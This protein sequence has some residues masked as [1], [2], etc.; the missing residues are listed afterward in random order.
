MRKELENL[1]SV[2]ASHH[3]DCYIVPSGDYHG[4]EYLND[5]FKTRKY[6]SGFTGSAGTLLVT[7]DE[8]KLWTDGRYFIQAAEELMDSGIDLMKMQEPDVPTI[9]EYFEGLLSDS[10][11]N[12]PESGK[13]Y[14]LGFDGMILDNSRGQKLQEI[15]E[16]YN[17]K[18]DFDNDLVGE[19]WT[20]RPALTGNKIWKLPLSSAGIDYETKIKQVRELM[21]N[22][23]VTHHFISGLAENAWLYNLRGSDVAYTPVFFSFSM[24]T[25]DSVELF[26]L[27]ETYDN[28]I[29][30]E[31]VTIR[32]YFD[33]KT[34]I[35]TL[36]AGA[37]LL[38]DPK[39]VSYA[40]F[41]CV[42]DG[43]EIIEDLSP[44]TRLKA[45]K[46]PVE[47][48]S[49]INAHIKDGVA[50]VNFI[51]WL[52]KKMAE[53]AS[54]GVAE[55]SALT[56]IT[57]SDYLEEQR[58]SQDG[59]IDLS[60]N[61]ISGYAE[62]GAIIHYGATPETD[63]ELKPEGF[64]LV[65]SGGQYIDG[66]TDITRT[67]ALGPLSEKMI[68]CYTSVLKGHIALATSEFQD[69]TTGDLLDDQTREPLKDVGLNYNHGTGHGI[70]HVLCVH[71]GPNSISAI[72][73][74]DQPII[75]GMITSDEPGVYLE[76]EFGIRIE[77]EILCKPMNP[78]KISSH[79]NSDSCDKPENR[80]P[81]WYEFQVITYCPFEPKAID[82][83]RLAEDELAFVNSYHEKVY[84][85][86]SPYLTPEVANWLKEECKPL[87]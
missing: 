84:K 69:G 3:I 72:G 14:T 41:K 10:Y 40:F 59:F 78:E 29:I 64:L 77:S 68:S 73:G 74:K 76:G 58:R 71:E 28:D 34:A 62:H 79:E 22:K 16:K 18:I 70:G 53:S 11:A 24:I 7:Q 30:P 42:P 31:D 56:E 23:G 57:A 26:L 33:I 5:Y 52:K 4:S 39:S 80:K 60:F 48:E 81:S 2:M 15:A 43:V 82:V 67:I 51:Y 1:R 46:N 20:D 19:I 32:N 49:T 38:M 75:P 61:T 17:A 54:E 86:L 27:P 8:A 6:I 63:K 21:I 9:E 47:I 83:S 66:T 87:H 65:D 36:P 55:K 45:I 13:A 12:T 37:S 50:M 25:M 35:R 85:T 44:V